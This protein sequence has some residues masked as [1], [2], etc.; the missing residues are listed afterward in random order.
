MCDF[1]YH[2]GGSTTTRLDCPVV[3][4]VLDSAECTRE[5]N[6]SKEEDPC[7]EFREAGVYYQGP[8]VLELPLAFSLAGARISWLPRCCRGLWFP[9]FFRIGTLI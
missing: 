7:K 5:D 9:D 4:V 8:L 2:F 6:E 3:F 1:V